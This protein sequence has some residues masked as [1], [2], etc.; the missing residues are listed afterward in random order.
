[1]KDIFPTDYGSD[2]VLK[3]PLC[4][5][6]FE[7]RT[8]RIPHGNNVPYGAAWKSHFPLDRSKNQ[9]KLG[10]T[11]E[12]ELLSGKEQKTKFLGHTKHDCGD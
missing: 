3:A 1:M 5:F 8:Q 4:G 10:N 9:T 7:G 2:T 11:Q 6:S 12:M